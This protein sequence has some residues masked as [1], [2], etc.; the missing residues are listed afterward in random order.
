MRLHNLEKIFGLDRVDLDILLI[1]LAPELDLRYE[2]IFAYLQ[3]DLA[4]KLPTV[5]LALNLA[6]SS[7]TE[8]LKLR[9]KFSHAAPLIKNE[10]IAFIDEK[11]CPFLQKNI[12]LDERI[13]A[14]GDP[15]ECEHDKQLYVGAEKA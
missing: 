2:Q 11:N 9:K 13:A 15:D 10:L 4:K 8:K 6:A 12:K 3:D 5:D 1:A 14:Q 7:R